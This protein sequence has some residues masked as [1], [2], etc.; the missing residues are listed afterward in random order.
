MSTLK[1]VH[2]SPV[3]LSRKSS[4]RGYHP[5]ETVTIHGRAPTALPLMRG[6]T[7]GYDP[8]SVL[9]KPFVSP[10]KQKE[11]SKLFS[12]VNTSQKTLGIR[13]RPAALKPLHDHNNEAAIVLW[14]PETDVVPEEDNEDNEDKTPSVKREKSI[15]EILGIAKRVDVKTPV[16]VDPHLVK[17]LRP[18]QIEGLKFMYR[19]TSGKVQRDA[20]G[21]IMADEMGLGKTLQ[22]IALIWTLLCQSEVLGKPTINKAIIACP[23]SLVRNWE[24]EFVK[25]LGEVAVRPMVLDSAESKEKITIIKQW[26]ASQGKVANPV[27]IISYESLRSHA[28]YFDKCPVG[29]LLC[30]EGHRLKNKDSMLF[31]ELSRIDAKRKVILSGTPIQ[32]ELIEYY[33]LLN[34]INPGLLGTPES[35]RRNYDVPI[36]RGRDVDAS[37]QDHAIC[38]LKV[39]ELWAIVSKFTI[40]RTNNLLTKYLP[41]KYEH[42]VFCRPSNIQSLLYKNYLKSNEVKKHLT[43]ENSQPLNAINILK[44][45]CNHPC[46][47]KPEDIEGSKD[48][49]GNNHSIN[50]HDKQLDVS[51][52]GKFI[53]LSRM[54]S[55]VKNETNDKIVLI[56][57]YTQTLDLFETLCKHMSYGCL[58]LDGTI[59]A[60]KR[61]KLVDRFNDPDGEEFIFLLSSKAGGCG[62]N[63]IGANR[64]VLFD[65]DWNPA[66]DQ[67]AL[68]RVWRDGQTKD[69]FIYRLITSGTIEEKIFQ[70]QSHKQSLSNCVVDESTDSGRHFSIADMRQLFQLNTESE[71]ETHETFKCKRCIKGKQF[72][73]LDD[74]K[75]GECSTWNHYDHTLTR[76]NDTILSE[77][78]KENT[79]TFAFEFIS[80][81]K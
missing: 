19:C 41:V 80:S 68:A 4:V 31:Q 22:C 47:L 75:Y 74:M 78:S 72:K 71:C 1:K 3:A 34:F 16:V 65:P 30:D 6:V 13:R 63:L 29:L 20:F 25:W 51:L 39:K 69:C 48:I 28:K 77:E 57:N 15:A 60:K 42:V 62:L 5:K 23:A 81:M 56:S 70:R 61:Q 53:V 18:H 45:L 9:L 73:S 55:K 52:S 50:S 2:T 26:A 12:S 36:A 38:D 11:G 64:L 27:L 43:D 10:L 40:R 66:S 79:V 17:V 54:L 7:K 49:L 76:L 46:L 21:C 33:A 32:N 59:N 58:R 14:N 44:K 24:K 35:F 67:Q 8:M 37:D